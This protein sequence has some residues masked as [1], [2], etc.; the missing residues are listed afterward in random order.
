MYLSRRGDDREMLLDRP[1]KIF[2]QISGAGHEAAGVAAAFAL[3][4][5]HDGLYPYFRYGA[6][7]VA[8]GATAYDMLLQAVGSAADPSSGGRQMPSHWSLPNLNIVTG[9]S[10]TGTQI[11]Q[12][13]GCAEVGRY[14]AA[15][16]DA[17]K[18]ADGDY[19][20]FKDVKFHGDE[21]TY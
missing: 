1:Q 5:G 11:L 20:Q 19:R 2:F 18:K 4:A 13:V 10:P 7:C 6:L 3:K 16:P 21:I 15:H 14:L 17:A 9:S 12:A 8:Y